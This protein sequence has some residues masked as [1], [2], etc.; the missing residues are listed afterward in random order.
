MPKTA[1]LSL[2][3]N[4]GDRAATLRAALA[5]LDAADGVRVRRLSRIYE[6]EPVGVTDQPKFLN[7]V[8]EVEV[9]DEVTPRDLLS[10][11][12]RIEIG[13]GRQPRERWGPR[14]IDIDLL[15]F[16]EERI[17]EPGLE[18][19]HPQTW[20]RGFVVI[21]LADLVPELR[22]PGGETVGEVAA[23]MRETEGVYEKEA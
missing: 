7:M 8:V 20:E 13:L 15:L 5:R 10:L 16:G 11:A 2:G 23:R 4:L 12:K 19:P 21:P 9:R 22:T 3:A 14:E 17:R 18:I 6:T 1:Y